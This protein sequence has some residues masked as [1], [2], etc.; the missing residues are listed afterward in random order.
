MRTRFTLFLMGALCAV[1]SLSAQPNQKQG[2]N[3]PERPKM[4]PEQLVQLQVNRKATELMLDDKTSAQ[5]KEVY[6]RYLKEMGESF[7]GERQ[8]RADKAPK[9]GAEAAK[10]ERKAPTD[11]E[12][13]AR[14]EKR[15]TQERKLL[16]IRE[17][18]YNELKQILTPRQ[19]Q[20]IFEKQPAAPRRNAP[21]NFRRM[22]AGQHPASCA[23]CPQQKK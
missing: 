4:T 2:E 1:S 10:P 14:I 19:L 18:Y 12:I 17:K 21:N 9:E 22:P 3:R 13:A 23:G 6:T 7:M 16:D 11:A 8:A 20:K 5:F 15:F